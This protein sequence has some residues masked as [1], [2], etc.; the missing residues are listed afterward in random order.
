M[1]SP[2]VTGEAVALDVRTAGLASRM[3]AALLDGLIQLVILFA[4]FLLVGVFGGSGSTAALGALGVV[5]V[6]TAGL[7]YPVLCETLMRGRT[8][9]KIALGLRVV[10]D[11]AGP[12][13][14]RQAFVRGLIGFIVERPGFSFYSVAVI[15]SLA[16]DSGK[17]LGDLLAGTVVIQERV[18]APNAVVAQMPAP[19]AAWASTLDLSRLPDELALSLRTF[20]ARSPSM[21]DVARAELGNR[22]AAAVSAVVTPGPPAGTPGWA[23]LTAVLAERRQRAQ[24]QHS[25]GPTSGYGGPGY[26]G[27]GYGVPS[28]GT[29][30]LGN[31]PQ[32][33]AAPGAVPLDAAGA[34]V[35]EPPPR[36]RIQ[37][38]AADA[39]GFA[40]PS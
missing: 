3:L 29:P 9:G 11:D 14:F 18:V 23:Y 37:Q 33:P 1:S 36:T 25:L 10:R 30:G 22:L 38:Q 27:P 13:G 2:L 8:P 28:Y 7:V 35:S 26:G 5:S 12:I 31:A 4:L 6:V 19:L 17:R 20:L 32:P 40:P 24:A 34:A 39:P 21:T 15:T 16:H